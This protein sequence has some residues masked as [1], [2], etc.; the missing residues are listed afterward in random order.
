MTPTI[1]QITIVIV[2]VAVTVALLLRFRTY[3]RAGSSKRMIGMMK[4]I[5]LNPE[6]SSLDSLQAKAALRQTFARCRKCPHED[7]CERWLAGEVKGAN[8]FCPNA[9]MFDNI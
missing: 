1:F 9:L 4:R 7:L 8:T 2:M 6:A 5:G 3:M